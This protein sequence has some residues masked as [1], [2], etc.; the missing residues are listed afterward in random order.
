MASNRTPAVEL[1]AHLGSDG[2]ISPVLPFQPDSGSRLSI[3]SLDLVDP[4]DARRKIQDA[5]VNPTI[6]RLHLE[7]KKLVEPDITI[8]CRLVQKLFHM[9]QLSL[10]GLTRLRHDWIHPSLS[11]DSPCVAPTPPWSISFL[12]LPWPSTWTLSTR[13]SLDIPTR[14]TWLSRS[15]N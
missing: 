9:Q 15:K 2:P 8:R 7:K 14:A 4:Q 13:S 3:S 5:H 12:P 6:C 10:C 11:L 1:P